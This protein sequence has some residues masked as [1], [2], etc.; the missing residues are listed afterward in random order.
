M[1]IRLIEF[2]SGIGSQLKS[3]KNLGL[4]V[5]PYKTCEWEVNAIKS[6]N[7]IHTK[8]YYDYSAKYS[9]EELINI[10]FDYGISS[11]G[12]S[13]MKYNSIK[14]K[15]E[16]WLRET[17]NNIIATNNLVNIME[18]GYQDLDIKDVD[19]YTYLLTY[20]FPCSLAGYKVRTK[21]GL[22]NIENVKCGDYVLTHENRYNKVLREMSRVKE[23]YYKIKYI[24]GTLE[25][26]DEHPLYVL[27]D[28]DFK[29]VKVKDLKTTDM[30]TFNINKKS[31]KVNLSNET[32]W[33]LGRYVADG[34]YN[35]YSHNSINF[36]ISFD[37]EKEFLDNS[38]KEFLNRY[39][40]FK[41]TCWDYRI[42]DKEFKDLCLQFGTGSKTKIIPSWVN[43]LPKEQLQW[44]FNG[45]MSGDGHIRTKSDNEELMFSTVSKDMFVNLQDIIIK[46]Y[47]RVCG[48][49]IRHDNRKETFNDSYCGQCILTDNQT[50][51]TMVNDKI[52]T[53]I[54]SIEYISEKVQV[55]NIEVEED[56][57]YTLDNVIVHNCQDL[58]LAGKQAGMDKGSGTSSSMLWEVERILKDCHKHGNLPQVLLMEN[59]PQVVG[60]KNI[61]NFNKWLD[62]LKELG[63]TNEWFILNAKDFSIPQNRKRC[64]MVSTL[65]NYTFK[66]PEGV[67]LKLRL[68]DMLEDKVDEKYYLSDEKISGILAW[69]AH[70]KPFERVNGNNSICPTITARG[71]GEDHS[72]MI[73]YSDS[74]DDTTNLQETLLI[75]EKTKRGYKEAHDGD[76]VYIN[77]PHQKRGVVQD[78]MIQTLKTSCN[79]VGVVT[80]DLRIRK[81][82]PKECYRL[83]GF[84]DDDFNSVKEVDMSDSQCYKQ[85]G[86][87]IVVNVLEAI[88]KSLFVDNPYKPQ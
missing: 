70:Q 84:T 75:R 20:S 31:E 2:F 23:G 54:H 11:D 40:K 43:N 77:R 87:S 9:K 62:S 49:Y 34:H 88:F 73:I 85:A 32:L 65:G 7:A 35:K 55:Y 56:N 78:G 66:V 59:V 80:N 16:A 81:L 36:A 19:K 38:P 27:R 28:G 22:K 18:V 71:A 37:K 83:M 51:Q 50:N 64:Y 12:K 5:E 57:S 24:G 47:G 15:G 10:L 46:L 68:K 82:T 61:D 79:D 26:T 48:Q 6:Y 44:F 53:K 29:W 63:Y 30:M 42:A 14:R 17:Y 41:K 25:L 58:S 3:L 21:H 60:K 45:Y 33:L 69:K 1:K 86:N 39:K 74:L 72:G 13:P 76:G 67:E 8:D 4:D 52:C